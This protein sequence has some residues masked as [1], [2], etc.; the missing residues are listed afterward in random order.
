M[1]E[2]NT[3]TTEQEVGRIVGEAND[4]LMNGDLRHGTPANPMHV[5]ANYD[6]TKDGDNQS[7]EFYQAYNQIVGV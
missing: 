6:V 1:S 7:E 2:Q 3:L 5:I 4:R